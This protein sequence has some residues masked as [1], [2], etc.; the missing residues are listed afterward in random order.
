MI[1]GLVLV[2]VVPIFLGSYELSIATKVLI[3]AIF[4]ISLDLL[5][6]YTGLPSFGHGAPFGAAAYTTG[7]LVTHGYDN[8]G[9]VIVSGIAMATIVSAIFGF[10]A[11]RTA[12]AYF[13]IITLALGQIVFAVG[14]NWRSMTGGDDG[15]PGI[16]RPDFGLPWDMNDSTN[17]YF[18]VLI[19]LILAYFLMRRF[20]NSPFGRSLVGI[21]ENEPRMKAL[22][23]NTFMQKYICFIVAGTFAGLAGV[24]YAYYNG[25][26][27]PDYV[28]VHT[29]GEGMLMVILGGAGTLFGPAIGAATLVL[30]K[31][32]ISIWTDHWPLILGII[33][34]LTMLYAPRGVGGYLQSLWRRR[35][36]TL[37]K[38]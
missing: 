21:K 9:L 20:V 16:S 4:A 30:L 13:L 1:I 22:G 19:F 36:L 26:V 23:Y 14:W 33:F 10:L 29:A 27:H 37:W 17:F 25:Y 31:H 35:I 18:M 12:H 24:L 28:G 38:R 11:V 6:G 34:V 2:I 8:P 15:L 32:Y 3:F 5:M 7:I